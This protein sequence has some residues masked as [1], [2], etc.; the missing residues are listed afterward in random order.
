MVFHIFFDT[1]WQI[2]CIFQYI[3]IYI[4]DFYHFPDGHETIYNRP[5]YLHIL[6]YIVYLF[7]LTWFL[8]D[9]CRILVISLIVFERVL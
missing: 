3:F 5:A 8:N 9:L 1:I 7:I 2:V 6:A 4:N